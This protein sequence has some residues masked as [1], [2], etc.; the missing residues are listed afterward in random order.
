MSCFS[1]L[2]PYTQ[3]KLDPHHFLVSLL[4]IPTPPKSTCAIEKLLSLNIEFFMKLPF[5]YKTNSLSSPFPTFLNTTFPSYPLTFVP[6][7]I[8]KLIPPQTSTKNTIQTLIPSTSSPNITTTTFIK[9][10]LPTPNITTT[11]IY[12]NNNIFS[13]SKTSN[14]FHTPNEN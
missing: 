7:S 2:Q 5:P 9:P 8:V 12:T 4:V 6:A 14:Y 3:T 1:W 11:I 13:S 10:L